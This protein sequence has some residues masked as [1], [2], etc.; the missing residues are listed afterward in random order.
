MSFFCYILKC[1]DGTYYTG[2]TTDPIRRE[3][4]HNAGRGSRYTRSRQP[5]RLVYVEEHPNRI[6]A[7]RREQE[8]KSL[9]RAA[10][11]RL[12]FDKKAI[13]GSLQTG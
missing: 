1:A 9:T 13:S 10:K 2:W 8:I 3:R 12:I 4:E 5:V 11:Q 7:M 6:S